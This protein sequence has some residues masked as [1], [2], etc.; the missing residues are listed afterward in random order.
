DVPA[1][2]AERGF[3]FLNDLSIAAHGAVE[4]MQIAVDD[5]DEI[6][7]LLARRQSD[8]SERFRFV[9]FAVTQECPDLRV[10]D[11]LHPAI[12]E[13]TVEARLING[14]QRAET[15]GNRRELPE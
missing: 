6:V 14:H 4:A 12:L 15:H 11:R 9:G 13:I 5:K 8:R 3:Q 1:T 2:A 7:E 10:R